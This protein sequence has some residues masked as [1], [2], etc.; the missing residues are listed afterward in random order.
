MIRDNND[1]MEL[2]QYLDELDRLEDQFK[3]VLE[4]FKEGD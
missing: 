3:P 4:R 2:T 1:V